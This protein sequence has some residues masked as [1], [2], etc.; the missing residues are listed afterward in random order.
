MVT[1]C[2]RS[3]RPAG[4]SSLP[5]FVSVFD[6]LIF[7]RFPKILEE[8]GVVFARALKHGTPELPLVL[9]PFHSAVVELVLL[10]QQNKRL[11]TVQNVRAVIGSPEGAARELSDRLG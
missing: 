9:G 2:Q 11:R 10:A 1:R 3:C 6:A 4:Q 8:T 5:V 7:S